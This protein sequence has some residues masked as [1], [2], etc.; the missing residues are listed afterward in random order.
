MKFFRVATEGNT[1][2]GR[3]ITAEHIEQMAKNYDPK[4][5]AARIWIEHFRSI[6][7][8]GA[9]KAHGDVI[10]LKT[11]KNEE[12]K[13]V[14]LAQIEATDELKAI[15]K[16]SQKLYSSIEIQPNFAETGE[17]YLVGLA[18]TDSP[19]SLGTERLMFNAI[20]KEQTHLFSA[21]AEADFAFASEDKTENLLD[22]VK[23][24]FKKQES[25]HRQDYQAF[26]QD[27]SASV[28]QIIEDYNAQIAASN[29]ANEANAAKIAELSAK[30]E[31][32]SATL[33]QTPS[34]DYHARPQATG[35][36]NEY[37]TD[38]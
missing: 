20:E 23:A 26:Y 11:E 38:C 12:G 33:E 7:P 3:R 13:L 22:K 27:V 21:Y 9:F 35:S 1:I 34:N 31:K 29:K 10:A 8:D 37:E 5:Y 6:M 25:T 36:A 30:L 2:D 17:A 19:A 28:E 32:L 18:V 14:L 16:K 15:N 4:K 24:M